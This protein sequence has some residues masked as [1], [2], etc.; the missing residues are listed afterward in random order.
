MKAMALL[1]AVIVTTI[2]AGCGTTSSH[3]D[4]SDMPATDLMV[5]VTCSN[6]NTRFAGSIVTDGHSVPSVGTGHGT[7]HTAGH[8][9]VCSFHKTDPDG[10]I[11]ISVS[12]AGKVL[13]GSTNAGHTLGGVRA[14]FLRTPLERHDIFTTF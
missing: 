14:E 8:E 9:F 10:Q 12:E 11:S 3:R 4:Y 7:L 2:F 5:T 13:G 6:P 1:P